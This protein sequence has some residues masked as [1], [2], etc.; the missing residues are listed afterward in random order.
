[1]LTIVFVVRVVFCWIEVKARAH[2]RRNKEDTHRSGV[3]AVLR[4][5]QPDGDISGENKRSN[6][7]KTKARRSSMAVLYQRIVSSDDAPVHMQ[8]LAGAAFALQPIL[9]V[10]LAAQYGKR[11]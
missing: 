10:I 2:Q 4:S 11:S 1:M 7:T 8:Y 6:V 9:F 3:E 5:P